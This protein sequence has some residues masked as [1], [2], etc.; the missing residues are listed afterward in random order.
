MPSAISYSLDAMKIQALTVEKK[1]RS[2]TLQ[3]FLTRR[4]GCSRRKAKDLLDA[5]RV[6]VNGRRVWMAHHA[7]RAGDVVHAPGAEAAG[8]AAPSGGEPV[9]VLHEDPVFLVIDKPAGAISN[10]PGSVEEALARSPRWAG[11]S[12]HAVHRLDRDTTGCLILAT[13]PGVFNRFVELFKRGKVLKLYHAIVQGSPPAREFAVRGELDGH[14]AVTHARVLSERNGYCHL[15]LRIDTGRTHQIRRHLASVRLPLLG[16]P[17]HGRSDAAS[18][19]E[20]NVPR[21]MLHA[22]VI[23]FPHPVSGARLRVESPLPWDFRAGLRRFG[24]TSVLA[25]F[26]AYGSARAAEA[27]ADAPDSLRVE[28]AFGAEYLNDGGSEPRRR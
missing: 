18:E 25:C 21:Q 3:D 9:R 28:A 20:M 6:F 17:L 15:R 12:L 5:R 16:D 7:L 22:A 1:A 13:Q 10:G 27:P 4:L 19:A 2:E 14:A 11:A 24:L 23:E 8:A 26:M